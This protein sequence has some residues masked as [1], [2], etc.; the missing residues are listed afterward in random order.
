[1]KSFS[2]NFILKFVWEFSLEDSPGIHKEILPSIPPRG[3]LAITFT[4]SL[5]A[6]KEYVRTIRQKFHREFFRELF[7]ECFREF[8]IFWVNS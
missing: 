4:V 5:G 3:P 7:Q 6:F 1:M 2:Q 8:F